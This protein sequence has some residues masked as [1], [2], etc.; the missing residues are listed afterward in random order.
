MATRYRTLALV[1]SVL[2]LF[3]IAVAAYRRFA[4]E[5]RLSARFADL[6][7]S[8]SHSQVE[9]RIEALELNSRR[10]T[11]TSQVLLRSDAFPQQVWE[12]IRIS[13]KVHLF[14]MHS[15]QPD[16]FV[17]I[18]GSTAQI[19]LFELPDLSLSGDESFR[20]KVETLTS[21]FWYP[22]DRYRAVLNARLGVRDKETTLHG[23]GRLQLSMLAPGLFMD[24]SSLEA[25]GPSADTH[26]VLLER[27]LFIRLAT[28]L[29]AA[30]A[31]FLVVFF[32]SSA[33]VDQLV[34]QPLAFFAAIW[35]IRSILRAD[36]PSS[37]LI[38]IDYATIIIYGAVAITILVRWR[39]YQVKRAKTAGQCPFCLSEIKKEAT[40]CPYC[41]SKLPKTG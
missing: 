27:S 2:L 35:A 4:P 17:D 39:A 15:P 19:E 31:L 18:G 3:A 37:S 29:V 32:I 33:K 13:G 30:M 26:E 36:V 10:L 8:P 12:A 41:T 28:I 5:A 22:F 24:I 25:E 34:W 11:G 9:L 14:L 40:R 7:L 38:L 6:R 20:W 16:R 23:I 21:E 1:I